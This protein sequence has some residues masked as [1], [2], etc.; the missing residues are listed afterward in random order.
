QESGIGNLHVWDPL[1][2]GDAD[3]GTG[4]QESAIGQIRSVATAASLTPTFQRHN[5][6][7]TGWLRRPA[8]A[9]LATL[10]ITL[11]GLD[12]EAIVE[13]ELHRHPYLPV[14]IGDDEID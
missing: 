11:G 3:L 8:L 6:H 4:L 9:G 5:I 12:V 1:R 2:V 13:A 10:H 14:V 7:P